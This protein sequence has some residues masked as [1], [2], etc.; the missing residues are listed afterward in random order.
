MLYYAFLFFSAVVIFA[1][2]LGFG[3]TAFAVAGMGK[4]LSS[5]FLIL[6]LASLISHWGRGQRI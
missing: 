4:F 1:G 3:A 5:F 6:F 2:L